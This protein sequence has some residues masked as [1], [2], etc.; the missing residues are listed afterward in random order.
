MQARDRAAHREAITIAIF[1]NQATLSYSGG[2]TNSNVTTGEFV[3]TV[4]VTKTPVSTDYAAG[5]D[6]VYAISIVND[7]L[8]PLTG[9]TVEDDL[10]GYDFDGA[11]VYPLAYVE[12]SLVYF[13]NGVPQAAPTVEAGPP[14]VIS[15]IE[16]PAGGSALLLYEASVTAFAPLG[17]GASIENTATVDGSCIADPIVAAASIPAELTPELTLSKSVC[18][19]VVSGCGELTYTFV[20]QNS[21]GAEAAAEDAVTVEDTFDPILGDLEVTLDGETLTLGTDYE[22]DETTGLFR[23]IAGAVTVPAATFAQNSDGSWTTTPG[24][25]VLTVTGTV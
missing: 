7:G 17:D 10:G 11:T 23:T 4:T 8:T 5:D 6:V 19:S 21:G 24:V 1:Y 2:R 25:T 3:E 15:D 20:I 14:L 18:P 16:V 12:G 9:V 22:Y 13:V